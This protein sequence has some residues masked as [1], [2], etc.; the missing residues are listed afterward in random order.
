MRV[1]STQAL[2]AL[3][4]FARHGSVWKAAG[5]LHLTRSAV[6]HQLRLLERDL[7]FDLLQRIGKG[8]ALTT[9]GRRYADDVRQALAAIGDAAVK[10]GK[11]S[12]GGPLTISCAA[13]LASLWFCPQIAEFHE[14]YPDIALRI[15]TPGRLDEVSQPDVDVFIAFGYGNWPNRDV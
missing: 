13:G 10:H 12:I 5:E 3:D 11:K 15:Q 2:R 9:Q 6:S 7:G 14:R 1:P 4:S 8:V